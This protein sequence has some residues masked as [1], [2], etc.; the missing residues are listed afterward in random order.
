M[1]YIVL[2]NCSY[3]SVKRKTTLTYLFVAIRRRYC[4]LHKSVLQEAKQTIHKSH[5]TI[6]WSKIIGRKS[7]EQKTIF[8]LYCYLDWKGKFRVQPMFVISLLRRKLSERDWRP[9]VMSSRGLKNDT[10]WVINRLR[11]AYPPHIQ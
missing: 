5:D 2:V 6:Q 1:N 11:V 7:I 9:L 8:E 4:P 3:F 10:M